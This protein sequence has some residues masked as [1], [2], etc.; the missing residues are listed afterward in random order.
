MDKKDKKCIVLTTVHKVTEA[1]RKFSNGD[2]DLIVV[3]DRKTPDEYHALDCVF[4]DVKAQQKRW[5]R[6]S[7]LLPWDSYSR[8]NMGYVYALQN[9]YDV[10][11]ESDD[12]TVPYDDWGALDAVFSHTIIAPRYPNVYSLFT[13]EPIWPRG[14]PLEKIRAGEEILMERSLFKE[15]GD[16]VF[17]VQNL[18]DGDPDVDAVFRLVRGNREVRFRREAV[19]L[20]KGVLSPFNTQNTFWLDR[21]SFPFLYLP[22]T[23]TFRYC[24]ILRSYVAQHG[25]W[26]RGG[27]L[28]FAAASARQH[29]NPHDLMEDFRQELP[30]YLNFHKAMEALDGVELEGGGDDLHAMYRALHKSGIVGKDEPRLVEEWLKTITRP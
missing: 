1:V 4:L 19:L 21:R 15:R 23:T 25:I 24:D 26:R 12:D 30:M 6:L 11:A 13:D 8:K 20:D 28:A 22:A 10:I 9:G 5:P 29:R 14:F 16:N 27:R 2:Y 18:V 3:G 17:I 7:R